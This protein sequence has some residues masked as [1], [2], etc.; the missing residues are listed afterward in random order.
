MPLEDAVVDRIVDGMADRLFDAMS[1]PSPAPETSALMRLDAL[2]NERPPDVL[3]FSGG[4]SEYIYGRHREEFGDL[5]PRLA[6]AILA[7]ARLGPARRNARPEHPRDRRRRLAVHHPGQREHDLRQA[8][9]VL[10]LRNVPVMT[11]QLPLSSDVLDAAAIAA[12]VRRSLRRFDLHE[13]ESRRARLSLAGSATFARLDSLCAVW[14]RGCQ[15]SSTAAG[16]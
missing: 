5:G 15:R 10:P 11:P 14:W 3:I 7:R 6:T 1:T 16:R 9:T 12:A 2:R 4:V 8:L 13:G